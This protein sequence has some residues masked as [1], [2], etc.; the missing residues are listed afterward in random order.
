MHPADAC[1]RRVAVLEE[2]ASERLSASAPLIAAEVDVATLLAALQSDG[3]IDAPPAD[4]H[5]LPP[6]GQ[7]TAAVVGG[8]VPAY[9]AL[10]RALLADHPQLVCTLDTTPV[11][12]SLLNRADGRAV[13]RTPE[14]LTERK[15]H[16]FI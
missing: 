13:S 5:D 3:V 1:T 12:K 11:S 16:F 8:G 4:Q 6:A 2:Q 9:E 14:V 10:R 15:R 7:L